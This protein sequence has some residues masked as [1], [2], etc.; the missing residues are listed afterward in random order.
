MRLIGIVTLLALVSLG[1]LGGCGNAGEDIGVPGMS[2]KP[3]KF[4]DGTYGV[5]SFGTYVYVWDDFL[6]EWLYYWIALTDVNL[7]FVGNGLS[8]T[9]VIEYFEDDDNNEF[10]ETG[11]T[12]DGWTIGE[13]LAISGYIDGS[14]LAMTCKNYL[15]H[16][17]NFVLAV[18]GDIDDW[19]PRCVIIGNSPI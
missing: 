2:L 1:T 18:S 15:N 12:F 10:D 7:T 11:Q 19:T 13:S 16:H 8:G 3:S 6:S 5:D 14:V 4:V 17:V 9:A